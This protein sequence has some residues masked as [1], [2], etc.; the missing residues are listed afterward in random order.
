MAGHDHFPGYFVCET[1]GSFAYSL[2]EFE[3]ESGGA[4]YVLDYS[5]KEVSK[6]CVILRLL[7]CCLRSILAAALSLFLST[8]IHIRI[9]SSALLTLAH[10][11]YTRY[12]S[13]CIT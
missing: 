3:S 10:C 11:H 6:H 12:V 13:I 4:E 1:S 5:Q 2:N 7:S 8:C 9:S